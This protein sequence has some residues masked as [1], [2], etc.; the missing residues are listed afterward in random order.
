M[1]KA[2]YVNY[3]RDF[4]NTYHLCWAPQGTALPD[5]WERITRREAEN[6]CRREREARRYN[7][8][9]SGDADAHIFPHDWPSYDEATSAHLNPGRWVMSGPYIVE[10]VC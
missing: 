2:Y 7:S 4:S 1:K 8:G 10:G 5:G 6:L 9:F 3:Y